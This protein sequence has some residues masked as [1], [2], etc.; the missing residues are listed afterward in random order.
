M[1]ALVY[2]DQNR[3]EVEEAPTPV[4]QAGQ[5]LIRSELS[6]ICGSDISMVKYGMATPGS[7]LGHEL[8]GEIAEAGTGVEGWNVHDRVLVKTRRICEKCAYC[9]MGQ[10]H[11]CDEKAGEMGGGYA[12]YM[13]ATPQMLM[14]LPDDLESEDAVLWNPLA[15]S[16]H[17][18]KLARSGRN[19]IVMILGA[20][21]IGLFVIRAAK[22]AG[23][24]SVVVSDPSPRR[25]DMAMAFGA[26]ATLDP[27]SSDVLSELK[28]H[29]EIGPDI[30]FDCAGKESTL[31]EATTY[32]KRGGQVVL[33]GIFM[34]PVTVIPLFWILKEIDIQ[35]GFGYVDSDIVDAIEMLRTDTVSARRMVTSTIPVKDAPAMFQRLQQADE[36][37]KVVISFRE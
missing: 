33:F 12:E 24:S 23:A 4:P 13:V 5:L 9:R 10:P 22:R 14:R 35:T 36:E 29:S 37:I 20:G 28:K 32:V 7:I 19:G 6:G 18:W 15:N 8:V 31:Q 25:R 21:P 1:K 27:T 26:D 30:V 16:L 2:K 34:Q 3:L 17:A 11:L